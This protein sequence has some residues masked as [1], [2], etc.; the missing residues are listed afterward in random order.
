MHVSDCSLI[1][2]FKAL[3]EALLQVR[4][5]LVEATQKTLEVC[6][7]VRVCV[8]VHVCCLCVFTCVWCMYVM[9]VVCLCVGMFVC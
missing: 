2:F 8:C 4:A 6:V 7:C 5:D 1:L 3:T 9:C